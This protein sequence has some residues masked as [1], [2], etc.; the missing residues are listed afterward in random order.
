MERAGY[1]NCVISSPHSYVVRFCAIPQPFRALIQLTLSFHPMGFSIVITSTFCKNYSKSPYI[2]QNSSI[3]THFWQ[4]NFSEHASH[5]G[6]I[7]SSE[8]SVAGRPHWMQ[9]RLDSF[10]YFGTISRRI[11]SVP[12]CAYQR[13]APC[14]SLIC[15]IR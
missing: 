12:P 14:F 15:T 6:A 5:Q 1:H 7:Q 13:S 10:S 2:P 9:I 8:T 3:S 11:R 4:P